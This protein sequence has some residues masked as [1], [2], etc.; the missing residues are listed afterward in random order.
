MAIFG[1]NDT[2][3]QFLI[4]ILTGIGI[5]LTPLTLYLVRIGRE[6]AVQ[7]SRLKRIEESIDALGNIPSEVAVL[8]NRMRYVER[9]Y[10]PSQKKP[11]RDSL[12]EM[13]EGENGENGYWNA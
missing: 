6:L 9:Y 10:V 5:L 12:K 4:L 1:L 13:D 11:R 2:D 8:K 3:I 7:D